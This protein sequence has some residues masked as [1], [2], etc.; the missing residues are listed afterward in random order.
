MS[1]QCR[2][3]YRGDYVATD[4]TVSSDKCI[5]VNS[6]GTLVEIQTQYGVTRMYPL[7]VIHSITLKRTGT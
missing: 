6:A 5:K 4:L 1:L 2:V 7:D 3:E